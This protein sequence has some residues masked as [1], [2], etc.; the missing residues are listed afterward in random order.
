MTEFK[1]TIGKAG[2]HIVNIGELL[3]QLDIQFGDA[4]EKKIKIPLEKVPALIGIFW[5]S[6]QES[7]AQCEGKELVIDFGNSP[8]SNFAEQLLKAL[9][10]FFP[11]PE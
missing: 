5:S 10:S 2:C 7:F 4:T 8:A 3:E 9:L 6:I 1:T 11:K